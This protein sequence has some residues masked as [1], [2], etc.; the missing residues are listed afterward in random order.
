[1]SRMSS[2]CI[3]C[4]VVKQQAH[5][6]RS[7]RP[8]D[9]RGVRAVQICYGGSHGTATSYMGCAPCTAQKSVAPRRIRGTSTSS[10]RALRYVQCV[11]GKSRR[12]KRNTCG[13]CCSLSG[14]PCSST[15][16]VRVDTVGVTRGHGFETRGNACNSCI[17][18][19]QSSDGNRGGILSC[20][21]VQHATVFTARHWLRERVPF[22]CAQSRQGVRIQGSAKR[23]EMGT[24]V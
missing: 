20:E 14:R 13:I 19:L 15:C 2:I 16:R 1:M 8:R 3:I 24:S 5:R 10:V 6:L 17:S 21:S 11:Q 23:Q 7:G 22:D 4:G 18:C 9:A 12:A